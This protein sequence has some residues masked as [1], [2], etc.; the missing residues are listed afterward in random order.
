MKQIFLICLLVPSISFAE[1]KILRDDSGYTIDINTSKLTKEELNE[2]KRL[3]KKLKIEIES[4][5]IPKVNSNIKV[6]YI[7]GVKSKNCN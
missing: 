1:N 4:P 3:A 5:L 6:P 7:K 2:F